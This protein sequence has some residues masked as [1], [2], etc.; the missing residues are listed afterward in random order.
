MQSYNRGHVQR[1]EGDSV[2]SGGIKFNSLFNEL[3]FFRVCKPGLAPCIG[4]YL[5][6]RIVGSNLALYIQHLVKISKDF[7][8]LSELKN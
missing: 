5:F 3:S 2:H 7:T 4:H 6:E 1:L 8:Y